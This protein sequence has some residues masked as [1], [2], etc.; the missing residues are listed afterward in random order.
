M[1]RV[2]AALLLLIPSFAVAPFSL[3]RG[4]DKIAWELVSK[5]ADFEVY[6]KVSAGSE[7]L[8]AFRGIGTLSATPTE[9]AAGILDRLRRPT[10]MRDVRELRLVR[11]LAPG[12]FIE[13]S[14]IKT[15]FVVKDRD[16]LVRTD[17]AFDPV[18]NRVVIISKSVTDAA[19]PPTD[20]VR[21]ELTE[22]HFVI[23]PGSI[24]GTSRLTAD[25][26]VDPKGTVPRWITNHF[27][28][29]WPVAMFFGLK[30]F[31]SKKV[32]TMPDDLRPIFSPTPSLTSGR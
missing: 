30:L 32:A 29:N 2:I 7:D 20:W 1:K 18:K 3:A 14:S 21:G 22:G 8:F 31:L 4:E 16:F 27:Q 24:P 11:A 6:R 5:H 19:V 10:W 9:V 26:D 15:P 12:S 13:Y 23:E 25:M 17:V 28:K